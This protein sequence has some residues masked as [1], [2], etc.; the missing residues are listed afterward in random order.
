MDLSYN[1]LSE[2]DFSTL[3][4][5]AHSRK[6]SVELNLNYNEIK[7][8]RESHRVPHLAFEALLLKSN[9][10][11]SFTCPDMRIGE[12]HLEDNRLK[13]VSFDNCSV[14]YLIASH[15]HLN[16]LHIHSDLKGFVA[17][18]NQINSFVVSGD[19]DS[20]VYHFDLSDNQD[21]SH[22][23]PSLRR[24]PEMQ[25]LNLS[26]SY[27][28]LLEEN[29]FADMKELKYVLL[30]N[31]G[32][33]SL[34]YDIFANNKFLW[35]IDLSDNALETID[36]TMFTGLNR[37]R[38]L[39]LSGNKLAKLHGFERV[40]TILPELSEIGIAGNR[41]ECHDLSVII[42]TFEALG[43]NVVVPQFTGHHHYGKKTID[44]IPCY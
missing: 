20:E 32:L 22:V 41:F 27:V 6:L 17:A 29:A 39:D 34:P 26:H 43:I 13:V 16:W 35:T 38:I 15:N 44:G 8:V 23:W 14:E 11:E 12:L 10:L 28:G 4:P 30:K 31:T 3:I 2:L 21:V 7:E 24:M 1:R 5:L 18:K 33:E 40:R 9:L 37:L 19:G 36:L 42:R 25:F